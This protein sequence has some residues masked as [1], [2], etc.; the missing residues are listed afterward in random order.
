MA[1]VFGA[2]DHAYYT[3]NDFHVESAICRNALGGMRIL[4]IIFKHGVQNFVGRQRVA[5]FLVGPQFCR[6][7]LLERGLWD[8]RAPR[9]HIFAETIYQRFWHVGNDRQPTDHVT[10]EC[11]VT[12]AQLA[13]VAGGEHDRSELIGE[14]HQQ[15]APGARLN[16]FFGDVFF[17]ARENVFESAAIG[18]V[19]GI[20]G[21]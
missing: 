12:H 4:Y 3:F 17:R 21:K 18:F 5:V 11:A 16:V 6:G 7:R 9:I 13:L 14:R 2:I 20:D 1:L 8:H 15:R 19:G 10:I